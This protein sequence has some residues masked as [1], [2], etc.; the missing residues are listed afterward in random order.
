MFKEDF[1]TSL[2]ELAALPGGP[3]REHEVVKRV[4]EQLE[5]L[6]DVEV[7]HMGNVYAVLEGNRP[8]PTV[9]VS[10]H[11][12]EIGCM[13]SAIEDSGFLRMERTGG[14]MDSLL[15]GRKVNVNGHFGVVGVKSGH[16]Q[17]AAERTKVVP[18][19]ELYVDIGAGSREEV[20]E[21][22]VN[23]GDAITYISDLDRFTNQDLICGKAIDNRSCC[24]IIVELFKKLQDKNFGGKIVGVI[25]VQE[26]VGLRGAKAATYKVSPDYALVI[27]TIACADTPDGNYY[28][29]KIGKGP[30]LP[31]LSGGGAQGNIMAPQMK[32]LIVSYAKQTDVP[33]QLSVTPRGTSDLSAVHLVKE[34]VLGGAI[35]FPRRYSHSPVEMAN[36]QDFEDGFKLL[37]AMLRDS[38]NWGDMNFV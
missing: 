21:M 1:Y 32:D 17:T 28:P 2:K 15:T 34:G 31:L 38:E 8:G 24:V 5:P 25:T 30:V 37:E 19:E 10:A 22:G 23:I 14:M 27:D 35:T 18:I 13:V 6:A 16:M 4:V 12:D 3:G 33:V 29:I 36:L 7:D 26:E 11:S 20:L 9:M